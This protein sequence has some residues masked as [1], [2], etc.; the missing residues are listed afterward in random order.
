MYK[1]PKME[2]IM[3]ETADV[4]TTSSRFPDIDDPNGTPIQPL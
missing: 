3:M 2:I 1:E 4:I